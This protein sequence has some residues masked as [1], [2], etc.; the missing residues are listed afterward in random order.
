MRILLDED[1]PVQLI[2][3]MKH[4]LPSHQIDHVTGLRGWSGKADSAVYADA[5]KRRYDALVTKDRNQLS[6]PPHVTMVRK[7]GLHRV[8][9]KQRH[10]GLLGLSIAMGSVLAA[11]VP[12]MAE[13]IAAD[14][15]RLVHITGID[16]SK[17][18]YDIVDPRRDPPTYWRG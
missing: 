1:T 13:L 5:K 17:R 4:V 7:S 9:F 12:V 15:Q 16:P 11:I 2:E 10:V 8:A 6:D 14:G 3:P 18:R